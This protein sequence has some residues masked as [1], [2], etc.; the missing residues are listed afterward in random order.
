MAAQILPP[1][2]PQV[3]PFDF[4]L[5]HR[6]PPG[7]QEALHGVLVAW[8][9]I[10][11]SA[12]T[13]RL[14][15]PN[16]V[17]LDRMTQQTFGELLN[18]WTGEWVFVP[19]AGTL[20]GVIACDTAIAQ[21][22]TYRL[23]GGTDDIGDRADAA[24]T[25]F[26][27]QL[28]LQPVIHLFHEEWAKLWHPVAPLE[29]VWDSIEFDPAFLSARWADADWMLVARF[30]W[31][32]AGR[33]GTIMWVWSLADLS[34]LATQ[35]GARLHPQSGQRT[36]RHAADPAWRH[37]VR[38]VPVPVTVELGTITLTVPEFL[39]LAPGQQWRLRTQ[40]TDV[41]PVRWGG[42]VRAWGAPGA[43]SGR[44]AIQIT[45]VDDNASGAANDA[46][47]ADGSAAS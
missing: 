12:M 30:T 24:L 34:P 14:S 46:E 42:T 17:T 31:A 5:P 36:V 20:P 32:L 19:L 44:Y 9:R 7:A 1:Q 16:T 41:L 26:E 45:A 22:V 23:M 11:S 10:V 18:D 25:D 43:I 40:I 27:Q 13:P 38:T 35:L 21:L 28:W 29:A 47:T 3:Q 33:S 6:L 4:Q 15:T 37:R 2:A 39:Q 8:A